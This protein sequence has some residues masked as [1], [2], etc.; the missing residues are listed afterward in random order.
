MKRAVLLTIIILALPAMAC[1]VSLPTPP[2]VKTG[3]TE[4][5]AVNE[6]LPTDVTA[7]KPLK[8][9]LRLGAGELKLAGGA[10]GL[11]DGDIQ[12][13]VPEWKPIV[14]NQDGRLT[15]EQG[16]PQDKTPAWFPGKNSEIVNTWDLKLGA[17]PMDLSL[18]AGAYKGVA[19][20]SGLHLRDLAISDGV[21]DSEVAFNS[22][23]PEVMDSFTYDTGA[24][25]VRLSGLGYANFKQ[26]VFKGGAGDYKL[27]F[28]GDLQQDASVQVNAGMSSIRLEI[29]AATKA[30][31]LVSGGVKS[32]T[33]DGTW[34][35]HGDSYETT[36]TSTY[37]LT[38]NVD[39][40]MGSLTLVS[41][42]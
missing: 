36:G 13:N 20:L 23:N 19:D 7:D 12:Y 32:V 11:V 2:T 15:I 16:Q 35:T 21:S 3:P 30:R 9:T 34:T 10:D 1:S 22:A 18:M 37:T 41:G 24:S 8:V 5:L 39:I 40:G 38:I 14:T 17:T 4:T 6:P 28:D 31:V 29:P 42:K 26:M 27:N 33:T 25:S